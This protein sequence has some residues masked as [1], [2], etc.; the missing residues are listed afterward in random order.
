MAGIKGVK[1][2]PEEIKE[3]VREERKQG[4]SLKSLSKKYGVK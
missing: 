3:A 2:Y 1:H 4:A